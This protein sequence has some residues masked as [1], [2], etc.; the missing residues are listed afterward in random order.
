MPRRSL[1]AP[2]WAPLGDG[3]AAPAPSRLSR[4]RRSCS[5]ATKEAVAPARRGTSRMA[6]RSPMSKATR[7][8]SKSPALPPGCRLFGLT[9]RSLSLG[10]GGGCACWSTPAHGSCCLDVAGRLLPLGP[11]KTFR[12][13]TANPALGVNRRCLCGE[14]GRPCRSPT[15]P[16]SASTEWCMSTRPC[17][18]GKPALVSPSSRPMPTSCSS[19]YGELLAVAHTAPAA[20]AAAAAAAAAPV[21]PKSARPAPLAA[22]CSA[23]TAACSAAASP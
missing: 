11:L 14:G 1:A 9:V 17:E 5:A 15:P 22:V 18:S 21:L 6:G 13:T 3:G 20:S 4:R 12:C 2:A 10:S 8:A 19:A 7:S 16:S 23:G